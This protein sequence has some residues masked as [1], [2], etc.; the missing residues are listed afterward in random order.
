VDYEGRGSLLITYSAFVKYLRKNGN[1]M[2]QQ[3]ISYLLVSR[4]LMIHLGRRFG[5]ISLSLVSP[6]N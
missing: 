5:I 6:W 1:T 4:K 2:K 3:C